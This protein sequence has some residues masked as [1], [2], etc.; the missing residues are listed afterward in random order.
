M[1]TIEQTFGE[2]NITINW[3]DVGTEYFNELIA[4][5]W[6][7]AFTQFGAEQDWMVIQ[8]L[9]A[10]GAVFNP[11]GSTDPELQ[12]MLDSVPTATPE[13]AQAT[14]A[15]INTFAVDNAWF[16]PW[17]WIDGTYAHKKTV[18]VEAQAFQTVPSLYN[19]APAG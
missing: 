2:L 7:I 6:P 14:F 3:T 13:D 10:P 1:Q 19:Y 16:A 8:T 4:G 11:L 5:K 18:E 12:A 9:M 15:E 17:Y